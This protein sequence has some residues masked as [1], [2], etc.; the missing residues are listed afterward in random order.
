MIKAEIYRKIS[1][2]TAKN[3]RRASRGDGG[4]AGVRLRW[5]GGVFQNFRRQ[6]GFWLTPPLAIPVCTPLTQKAPLSLKH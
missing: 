5:T 4:G 2:K 6:G 1:L 3:F